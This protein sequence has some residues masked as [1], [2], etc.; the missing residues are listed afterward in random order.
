M[1]ISPNQG[2][3]SGGT[4]VTITGVNLANATAVYFGS[5]LATIT[6]NTPTS[7]TVTNPANNGVE[8]VVVVTAGGT[9]NALNFYYISFPI[10]SSLGS[11]SGPTSGGNTITINGFN[12]L[13]ANSV[14]FGG[15]DATPTII[16]DSQI[17]VTVP[18]GSPGSVA[19]SVTTAGG[20]ASGLSYQYVDAPTIDSITPA[21]GSTLGGTSVTITGTNLSSTTNVTVGGAS[22]SFGVINNTTLAII[23]PAGSPGAVDIV[24]TT[25]AGS[26][27][28]TEAYT[29]VATPGI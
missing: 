8:R 14:S 7:I 17:S 3:V 19:V 2:S 6:S 20:T 24:V 9:S 22:A 16:S 11:I 1:P 28:A 5:T 13:T 4:T 27:T 21:S 29:Y 10:I 18:A 12:L 25:S 15:N 26:A 23:T